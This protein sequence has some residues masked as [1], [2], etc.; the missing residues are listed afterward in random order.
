M[1][2]AAEVE[3]PRGGGDEREALL[4]WL[5]YRRGAPMPFESYSMA[6]EA[7]NEE[8]DVPWRLMD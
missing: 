3:L 5:A 7:S 1:P 6:A 4:T 8:L 2:D